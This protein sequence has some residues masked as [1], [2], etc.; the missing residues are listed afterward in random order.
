MIISTDFVKLLSFLS[1]LRETLNVSL[2]ASP[3][4]L[5]YIFPNK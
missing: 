4:V 5:Y 1:G 2:E 3:H